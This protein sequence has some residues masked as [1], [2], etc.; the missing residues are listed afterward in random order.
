MTQAKV[1]DEREVRR[2]LLHIASRKHAAR[3]KAMFLC[4]HLAGMRIGE[5]AALRLCDVLNSDGTI[6]DEVR[7]SAQQTKGDRGRTVLLPK[8]LRL[9]WLR[10]N[11]R[12]SLVYS[13]NS[14]HISSYN[15]SKV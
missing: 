14:G 6:R 2:V 10:C 3:N 12:I 7:L 11:L 13:N 1:L 8:K 9:V 4:T 15:S 5:V